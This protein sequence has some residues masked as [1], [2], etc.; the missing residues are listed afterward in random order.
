MCTMSSGVEYVETL[1]ARDHVQARYYL[2]CEKV[3]EL[4]KLTYDRVTANAQWHDVD[5][6]TENMDDAHHQTLDFDD[7]LLYRLVTDFYE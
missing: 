7:R 2:L 4:L 6:L 1:K 3:A 5:Y